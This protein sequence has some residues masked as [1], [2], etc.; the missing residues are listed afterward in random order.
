MTAKISKY[1]SVDSSTVSA[2]L[3]EKAYL[4]YKEDA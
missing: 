1:L 2:I 4:W 3:R